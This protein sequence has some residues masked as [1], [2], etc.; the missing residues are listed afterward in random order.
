MTQISTLVIALRGIFANRLRSSLTI[1]GVIIGIA[2]VI[3]LSSVGE[4]SKQMITE[5]IGS[6]GSNLLTVSSG[7]ASQGFIRM[8]QGSSQTLTYEDA[9]AIASSPDVTAVKAVAPEASTNAQVVAG[10]ENVNARVYGVTP[11]Y[12][13]VRAKTVAGGN[14]ITQTDVDTSASVA[15]LGSG[16]GEDLFG[17]MNPVGQTIKIDKR[18]YTV[19]GILESEEGMMGSDDSIFIP[20]TS[21]MNRLSPQRD[22]EGDHVIGSIYLQ[23]VG[24]NQ[25][26]LAIAQVTEVLQ[27]EHRIALGDEDDFSISSMQDIEETLTETSDTL[28]MLLTITAAIALLVAGLGIMNIMLVSVTERTREIGIRKAVGAKRRNIL[29]QFL[30]EALTISVIGGLIGIGA[31]IGASKLLSGSITMNFSEI[32]TV[33]TLDTV[34][35]AF[36]VALGVGIVAGVYPAFRASRLNPIDALRYE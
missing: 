2:S 27:D 29:M 7:A 25:N 8:G 12:E 13:E 23:A 20:I 34:I 11:E 26:D 33:V 35:I 4:G 16:V 5:R 21:V 18:P 1:L 19:V 6:L 32:E 31:G 14:F 30:L 22:S 28:T 3:A 17:Q 10:G 36:F 15:V 9:S 24:D